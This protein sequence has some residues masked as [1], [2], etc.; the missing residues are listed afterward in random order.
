M[1]RRIVLAGAVILIV[2]AAAPSAAAPGGAGNRGLAVFAADAEAWA[3]SVE[4]GIPGPVGPL[5]SHTKAS[6]DNS[7]HA[8]GAAG[9]ADP[10]LLVRAVG[11]V[12]FGVPTPAHCESAAPEGP[13]EVNCA[14]PASDGGIQAGQAHSRSSDR[15]EATSTARY[16]R[17][18]FNEAAALDMTPDACCLVLAVSVESQSTIAITTATESGVEARS[19]VALQGVSLAGGA[20]RIASLQLARTAR[21]DGTEHGSTTSTEVTLSGL[22][23]AGQTVDPGR[24]AVQALTDAARAAYGDRMQVSSGEHVEERTPNGKVRGETSGLVVRWQPAPDRWVRVILGYAHALAYAAP[25]AASAVPESA[26]EVPMP[27]PSTTGPSGGPAAPATMPEP[28]V[29]PSATG[30]GSVGHDPATG[31]LTATAPPGPVE[32]RRPPQARPRPPTRP[33]LWAAKRR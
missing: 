5:A 1:R 18:I 30:D 6:I 22:S 17:V 32:R 12:M 10:G 20:V 33:P 16:G 13:P 21:A 4:V 23:V 19:R 11:E 29:P 27:V 14:A 2:L 8:V 24:D 25:A 3:F 26:T 15:P 7:P 31:G 28:P 9:L